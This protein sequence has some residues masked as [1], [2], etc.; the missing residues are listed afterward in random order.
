MRQFGRSVRAVW[1]GTIWQWWFVLAGFSRVVSEGARFIVSTVLMYTLGDAYSGLA[2]FTPELTFIHLGTAG[3]DPLRWFNARALEVVTAYIL[4]WLLVGLLPA[5]HERRPR[6]ALLMLEMACVFVAANLTALALS[7]FV[8]KYDWHTITSTNWVLVVFQSFTLSAYCIVG[9]VVAM[10]GARATWRTAGRALTVGLALFFI[11]LACERSSG[12]VLAH[13]F[14]NMDFAPMW[15]GLLPL[16]L[17]IGVFTVAALFVQA[18]IADGENLWM[19]FRKGLAFLLHHLWLA[20]AVGTVLLIS[21]PSVIYVIEKILWWLGRSYPSG[22]DGNSK[23]SLMDVHTFLVLVALAVASQYYA[24]V[25]RQRVAEQASSAESVPARGKGLL[26][27]K[28]QLAMTA[29]LLVLALVTVSLAPAPS[30]PRMNDSLFAAT[31]TT[32]ITLAGSS[33]HW[34]AKYVVLVRTLL[35]NGETR[36]SANLDVSWTGLSS[37]TITQ[38]RYKLSDQGELKPGTL[39][40]E[41]GGLGAESGRWVLHN[42]GVIVGRYSGPGA[43]QE[44]LLTITWKGQTET[45]SLRIAQNQ[46]D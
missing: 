2:L 6:H 43:T 41:S 11:N 46:T 7:I 5:R 42:E 22:F 8:F 35:K 29:P 19:A 1:H 32:T 20:F 3:G 14:S 30:S 10:A 33:A 36:S 31:T 9:V 15:A 25:K 45:M 13:L 26:A 39:S 16:V 44:L 38:V 21:N 23:F 34:D 40:A 4:G 24:D 27:V 28:W 12:W 37:E 17:M 18:A